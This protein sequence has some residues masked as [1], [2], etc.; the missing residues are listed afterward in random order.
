MVTV[1]DTPQQLPERMMRVNAAQQASVG[2]GGRIQSRGGRGEGKGKQR[3]PCPPH[4]LPRPS[5]LRER[6]TDVLLRSPPHQQLSDWLLA[7]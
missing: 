5:T 1:F 3:P 7:N 6:S 2:G 4:P